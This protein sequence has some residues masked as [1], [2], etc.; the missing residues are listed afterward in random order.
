MKKDKVQ[1]FNYG[2]GFIRVNEDLSGNL[3]VTE[4]SS[5][6]EG[7]RLGTWRLDHLIYL[8]KLYDREKFGEKYEQRIGNLENDMKIIRDELSSVL[9][10]IRARKPR[11]GWAK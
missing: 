2:R 10:S 9:I 5:D 8:A 7:V 1:K 4:D 11:F 6:G 3:I